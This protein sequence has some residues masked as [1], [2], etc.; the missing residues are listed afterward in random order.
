[1]VRAVLEQFLRHCPGVPGVLTYGIAADGTGTGYA[2]GIA[3]PRTG[4]RLTPGATF[5][6]ASNTK[7]FAAAT[8]LRSRNRCA[9]RR[10]A[11]PARS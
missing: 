8:A 9:S 7:T 5:R 4:R 2:A 1:M 6:T 3:D 10:R 11:G